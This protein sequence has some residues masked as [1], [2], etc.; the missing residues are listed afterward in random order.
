ILKINATTGQ[1][2]SFAGNGTQGFSGDGGL[3]TSAQLNLNSSQGIGLALDIAG[4]LYITDVGNNRVRMVNAGT[5]IITTVAGQT[6]VSGCTINDGG[7]P[8]SANLQGP[9]G[10]TL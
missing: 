7:P 1:M 4:N 2:S 8:T 9:S 10:V 3:A 6:C 5:G